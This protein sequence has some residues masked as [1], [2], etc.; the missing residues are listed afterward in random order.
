M[1]TVGTIITNT[2]SGLAS[3]V[4]ATIVTGGHIDVGKAALQ[5]PEIMDFLA[6]PDQFSIVVASRREFEIFRMEIQ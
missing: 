6:L 3:G 2:A 5:R 1:G 4:A